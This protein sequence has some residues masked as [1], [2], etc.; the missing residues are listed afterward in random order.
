MIIFIW[1]FQVPLD[2]SHNAVMAEPAKRKTMETID[3]ED[4]ALQLHRQQPALSSIED[5][6]A[7][8]CCEEL[9]DNNETISFHP[10]KS[11]DTSDSIASLM[12]KSHSVSLLSSNVRSPIVCVCP[13]LNCVAARRRPDTSRRCFISL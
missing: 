10:S 12:Q 5:F 1:T 3:D 9:P 2:E 4:G 13:C 7:D 11:F 6:L 8:V